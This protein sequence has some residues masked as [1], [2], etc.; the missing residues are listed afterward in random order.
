MPHSGWGRGLLVLLLVLAGAPAGADGVRRPAGYVVGI[1]TN[2]ADPEAAAHL[3]REG[4]EL[5]LQ[6]GG[7]VFDGDEVVVRAP[8]T[9]VSIETAVDRHVR[10]DAASSPHRVRGELPAG[11]GF[12][13]FA[14]MVGELFSARPEART[15]NLIG[16]TDGALKLDMGRGVPQR[17][18][19]GSRLWIGWRGGT[20][21]YAVEIRDS[22]GAALASASAAGP[23]AELALPPASGPLVL[24]VRDGAGEESTIA[25]VAT[26][27]L[28][29][30][31]AAFR[32]AAP[33]PAFGAVASALWLMA[34][35]PAEWDLQAA[36]L[37][38]AAGDYPAAKA[39]LRRLAEGRRGPK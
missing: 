36:A 13:A 18:V 24:A 19:P 11:G 31:P 5:A 12:S 2:A 38:A 25:L 21:P 22:T 23:S 37:A 17:V 27:S 1:E 34:R 32:D 4:Q 33:T 6:I 3:L 8:E 7:A 30:I 29:E 26:P 20:A 15:V 16:R 9:A 10:I 35:A 28:P 39:L 14:A